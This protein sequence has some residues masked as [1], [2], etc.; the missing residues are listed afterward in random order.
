MED[1]LYQSLNSYHKNIKLIFEVSL[2][3]FLDN[4]LVQENGTYITQLHRNESKLPTRW[5]HEFPKDIKET[6]YQL[7]YIVLKE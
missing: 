2:K 6:V 5:V 4:Y 7:I 1:E 3:K